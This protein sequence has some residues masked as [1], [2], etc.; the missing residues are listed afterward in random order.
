MSL[1]AAFIRLA[2]AG[3]AW[4]GGDGLANAIKFHMS[5]CAASCFD[6][7]RPIAALAMRLTVDGI[8]MIEI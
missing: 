1:E 4:L 8:R 2:P 3:L 7:A 5:G 6:L